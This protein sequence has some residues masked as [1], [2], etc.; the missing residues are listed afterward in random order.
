MYIVVHNIDK[1]ILLF[2]NVINSYI[3]HIKSNNKDF[4]YINKLI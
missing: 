2:V 1:V 4:K 3:K